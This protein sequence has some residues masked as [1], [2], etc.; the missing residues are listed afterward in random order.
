LQQAVFAQSSI[1]LKKTDK[2][3]AKQSKKGEPLG[4]NLRPT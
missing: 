4:K 3:P 2:Q 1:S